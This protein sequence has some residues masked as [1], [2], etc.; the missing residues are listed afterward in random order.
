MRYPLFAALAA[1][2][3]CAQ[4]PDFS[5]LA[6]LARRNPDAPAFRDAITASFKADGRLAHST[7]R[8]SGRTCAAAIASAC[9][10]NG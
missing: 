9:L 3:A 7:C 2:L 6:D 1:V 8:A 4:Q 10:N 5:A